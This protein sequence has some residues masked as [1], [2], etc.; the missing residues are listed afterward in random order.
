MLLKHFRLCL[1]SLASLFAA[2]SLHAQGYPNRAIRMI[3]PFAPGGIVDINGRAVSKLLEDRLGVPFVIENRAGAGGLVGTV[4][5][6]N[7]SPDGYTLGFV[8]PSTASKAFQKDPPIDIFTAFTP[9]GSAYIGPLALTTNGQTPAKTLKEFIDYAR[10]NPGKLNFGTSSGPSFMAWA[11]LANIAGIKVETIEYKGAAPAMTALIANEVQ[12][13]F[14][15]ISQFTPLMESGRVVPLGVAGDQRMPA[16]PNVPSMAELGYPG[17]KA[18]TIHAVMGPA[19]VSQA[20]VARLSPVM[21]VVVASPELEKLFRT[22]GKTLNVSN[23]ELMRLI[24]DEVDFWLKAGEI[25][26]FKPG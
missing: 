13:N 6:A 7:A 2:S 14:G 24:R 19:G 23:D 18:Y 21:K 15:A 5:L 12:A 16:I 8:V 22:S 11:V 20:V 25:A 26:R 4:A 3:V 10:A 17:V 9:I 1:L